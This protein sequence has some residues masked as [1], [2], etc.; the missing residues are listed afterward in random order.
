M[1]TLVLKDRITSNCFYKYQ[2]GLEELTIK[3]TLF[4]QCVSTL[5]G[6][7][8]FLHSSELKVNIEECDVTKCIGEY[9]NG[10]FICFHL[11]DVKL[12]KICFYDLK[13]NTINDFEISQLNENST[14]IE[15]VN[16][17][18]S[19][20][21]STKTTEF[22]CICNRCCID[23]LNYTGDST[24]EVFSLKS[25]C[26]L[27]YCF[28]QSAQM[29]SFIEGKFVVNSCFFSGVTDLEECRIDID[30]AEIIFYNSS[31]VGYKNIKVGK[32]IKSC[33]FVNC[34]LSC[35]IIDA[36]KTNCKVTKVH[37]PA[38]ASLEFC[39]SIR[40]ENKEDDEHKSEYHTNRLMFDGYINYKVE[41]C[42]FYGT[43]TIGNGGAIHIENIKSIALNNNQFTLCSS[44]KG[45]ALYIDS[46]GI[47]IF[48][49]NCFAYCEASIY[50]Q[51]IIK[52]DTSNASYISIIDGEN[53]YARIVCEEQLESAKNFN[54]TNCY[55]LLSQPNLIDLLSGVSF[56]YF[57]GIFAPEN[58]V[59]C[60]NNMTNCSFINIS[61]RMESSG[62]IK[63]K[64]GGFLSSSFLF[65]VN[66]NFSF[67]ELDFINCFT[68]NKAFANITGMKYTRNIGLINDSQE[69]SCYKYTEPSK[70]NGLTKLEI[71]LIIMGAILGVLVVVASV[72]MIIYK[73]G[74]KNEKQKS[75]LGKTI[76]DDFG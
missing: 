58:I 69:F 26:N 28:F 60:S 71:G 20:I 61:S 8:I 44:E 36:N 2:C 14:I 38:I 35:D 73:S 22:S 56:S 10:F 6:G 13:M 48:Q 5:E 54:I 40:L 29:Y 52:S 21:S 9:C 41:E 4:T 1:K 45:G 12:N 65:D 27:S 30:I 43:K 15:N 75:E 47:N 66:L 51:F 55:Y 62:L 31:F 50:T 72:L 64:Q 39:S 19:L 11:G 53:S 46:C 17:R 16:I 18:R 74:L 70:K 23:K 59:K 68:N 37:K 67:I 33:S 57:S 32:S 63:S 49:Y 42:E 25:F 7:A 24:S 76:I 3:N 34:I